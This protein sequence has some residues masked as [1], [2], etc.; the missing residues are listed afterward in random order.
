MR[1]MDE[2]GLDWEWIKGVHVTGC[3]VHG[4][5]WSD[6]QKAARCYATVMEECSLLAV[7]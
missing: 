2:D 6:T 1:K 5:W 3:A 7:T 4:Q